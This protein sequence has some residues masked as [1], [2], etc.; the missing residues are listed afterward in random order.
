MENLTSGGALLRGNCHVEY[1]LVQNVDFRNSLRKSH[2]LSV[3][4]KIDNI[5]V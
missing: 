2:R 1:I 4:L 5:C 3:N